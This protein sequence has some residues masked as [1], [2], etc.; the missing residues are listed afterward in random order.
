MFREPLTHVIL[1]GSRRRYGDAP[2]AR[3][4]YGVLEGTVSVI[5][6]AV[7][8]AVKLAIAGL[9][10]SVALLADAIHTLGD[11]V[12]SIII[13]VASRF[14]G[15][16]A[17]KEH[18]F[19]HGRIE[20][21]SA[22]VIAVLLAVAAI[23]FARVSIE[24]LASPTPLTASWFAIGVI[25]A[26]GL[27]KAWLA[28]FAR[29]VARESEN[30]AIEADYLHHWSDALSTLLVVVGMIGAHYGYNRLDAVM[31]L[32]VSLFILKAGGDLVRE[33][34][35]SLLGEPPS[36][37]EID[38]IQASARAVAGVRGVHD[39][40]VHRYGE[41]RVVSL[42]I[43]TGHKESA[44]ELHAIAEQVQEALEQGVHGTVVV[45]IDPI[46]D[47]HP[48]YEALAK[49]IGDAVADDARVSSFHDLRVV[50]DGER[51]TVLV[52]LSVSERYVSG[53]EGQLKALVGERIQASFPEAQWVVEVEPRF[54]YGA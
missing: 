34:I 53:D 32:G 44:L 30:R 27:A 38:E 41:L 46:N 49:V 42:H 47:E 17:D 15:K 7:L 48:H 35:S 4:R 36:N 26:S 2:D 14:A 29:E 11:C 50:G 52:D 51:F 16:P 5:V 10:G 18:P 33:A 12:S 43:E 54:A 20:S 40:I 6:N 45:H 1:E 9:T 21:V 8:V 3:A 37:E 39:I 24:R 25:A 22:I 23:E 19:G 31:G 28:Y 13:I